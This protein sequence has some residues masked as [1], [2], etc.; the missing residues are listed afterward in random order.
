VAAGRSLGSI[1]SAASL[2]PASPRQHYLGGTISTASAVSAAMMELLN[3]A[4][5]QL[6]RSGHASIRFR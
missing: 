5:Q 2:R 1:V 4:E 6:S 3:G